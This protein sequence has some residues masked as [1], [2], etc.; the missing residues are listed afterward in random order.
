MPPIA[1]LLL[2][3]GASSRL[4]VSK[5]ELLRDGE[6]LADRGARLVAAVSDPALE[7]GPGVTPLPAVREQP[8]GAGPLAALI[9]GAHEATRR[10]ATGGVLLLAVDLPFVDVP[11]LAWLAEHPA[12]G[13]V[14]PRVDGVPQP[15]CARYADS[16]LPVAARLRAA[17]RASMRALLDAVPVTYVD[18]ADW[19]PVAD[20]RAFL[21]VDTAAAVRRAGLDWPAPSPGSSSPRAS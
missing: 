15:L 17:G 11:L 9:A 8:A 2:T 3:G 21:D 13:A 7:V 12:P 5:A 19:G 16:D 18:E 6:R 20:R 14:V 4:G 1:G 10:H